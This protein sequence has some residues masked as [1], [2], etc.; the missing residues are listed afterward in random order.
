MERAKRILIKITIYLGVITLIVWGVYKGLTN[1]DKMKADDK[2]RAIRLENGTC[3]FD[4]MNL[5]RLYIK[6]NGKPFP[7]VLNMDTLIHYHN[8]EM[9]DFTYDTTLPDS[10]HL[11]FMLDNVKFYFDQNKNKGWIT[12][13][14]L[15]HSSPFQIFSDNNLVVIDPSERLPWYIEK[16]PKSYECRAEINSSIT[17]LQTEIRIDNSVET[18]DLK[19]MLLHFSV[20]DQV[21]GLELGY[22]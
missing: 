15:D 19:F 2:E 14:A 12:E 20:S 10:S 21:V 8:G 22:K 9:Y 13:I 6:G 17:T 18:S 1:L 7:F 11:S 16:F 5:D 4:T 3:V